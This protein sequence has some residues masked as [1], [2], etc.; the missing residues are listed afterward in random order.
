MVLQSQPIIVSIKETPKS[1]LSG[2]ADVLLGSLGLTGVIVIAAV[3][4]GALMAGI[5]FWVRSRQP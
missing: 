4:L 1:E 5:M 3:L 2:L